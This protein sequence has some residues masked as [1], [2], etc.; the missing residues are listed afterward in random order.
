MNHESYHDRL[1]RDIA[2][3]QRDGLVTPQ[4]ATAILARS[5]GVPTSVRALRLGWFATGVSLIGAIVLAGGV[6]LLFAA[7]WEQIPTWLRATSMLGAIAATYAIAHV[8]TYRMRMERVGSAMLL[9]GAL[10]F[11]AAL[12]LLA[13]IYNMPLDSPVLALLAAAGIVPLAYAFGSRIVLLLAMANSVAWVC[14]E[15][16]KRYPDSP[17]SESV[18]LV[19]ATV[20]IGLYAIGRL[21][22][23][24]AS[25][26]HFTE[27][28]VFSGLLILLALV[29]G[30]TF[31]EPWRTMIRQHV[32]PYAAPPIV[33]VSIGIALTLVAAQW[34]LRGRDRVANI[35]AAAGVTLLVIGAIVATWP[36]WTGYALVF[37]AIYFAIAGALVTRGYLLG[38]ERYINTG[39]AAVAIGVLT[40]YT[41]VFWSQLA[42]SAFFIVGGVL[43]LAV[44][45]GLER[46]RRSLIDAAPDGADESQAGASA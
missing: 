28:Y 14:F 46:L 23:L 42:N 41:D 2:S 38:E 18:L 30:F 26:A 31:D 17:K 1:F 6:V 5:G 7:N 13:Q 25:L 34:L 4:Q 32:Q 35:E 24:R 3:W 8:L 12:F 9:L 45:F 16:A 10:L 43:L 29:Y 27:T 36:G 33:Y 19:L 11:E 40:R 21:H 15:L 20:G 37:N 39:L 44:A 22:E